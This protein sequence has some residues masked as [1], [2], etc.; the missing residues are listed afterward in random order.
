MNGS[1][2]ESKNPSPYRNGV[3]P[4]PKVNDAWEE[5][6]SIRTF[7]ITADDVRKLGKDLEL[8]VKFPEE[9]GFGLDA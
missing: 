4:D 7:P 5:L 3:K 2:F 1:L 9:H 8:A 6:D